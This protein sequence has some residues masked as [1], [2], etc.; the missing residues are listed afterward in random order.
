M[1]VVDM[2]E[3]VVLA[4]GKFIAGSCDPNAKFSLSPKMG[5]GW[6]DFLI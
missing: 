5:C 6:P 2:A 3:K 4:C 1:V